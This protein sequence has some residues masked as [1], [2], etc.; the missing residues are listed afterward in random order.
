MKRRGV[1]AALWVWLVGTPFTAAF[2]QELP[3]VSSLQSKA[4]ELYRAKRYAEAA[5]LY[6]QL[7]S[8]TPDNPDILQDLLWTLWYADLFEESAATASRLTRLHPD[9]AQVW[10]V[11]G[12]S[13]YALGHREE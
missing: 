12:R 5:P 3:A 7:S 10:A 13:H 4:I 1:R 6:R 9:D 8:Q 11:L 2:A